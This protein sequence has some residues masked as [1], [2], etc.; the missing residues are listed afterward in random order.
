MDKQDGLG[1]IAQAAIVAAVVLLAGVGALTIRDAHAATEARLARERAEYEAKE[2]AE[3]E[4][5]RACASVCA[6]ERRHFE[7][8]TSVGCICGAQV[9]TCDDADAS[10]CVV[11]PEATRG[12]HKPGE[13]VG[14][15]L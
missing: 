5:R 12:E 11:Q 10:R 15:A 4:E 14:V 6:K 8:A 2:K 3:E 7:A 1:T 9:P 13:A